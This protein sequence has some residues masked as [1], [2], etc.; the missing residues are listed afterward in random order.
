MLLSDAFSLPSLWSKSSP[1]SESLPTTANPQ[2]NDIQNIVDATADILPDIDIPDI[3]PGLIIAFSIGIIARQIKKTIWNGFPPSNNV[4]I[5]GAVLF[6]T[7][8]SIAISCRIYICLVLVNLASIYTPYLSL[9]SQQEG[10]QLPAFA[11]TRTVWVA[12]A[13]SGIKNVLF[14]QLVSGETLGRVEL[15]DRLLDFGIF[16]LASVQIVD[17]L[18][19]EQSDLG[20][21]QTSLEAGKIFTIAVSLASRALAENIVGGITL[22]AY[23]GFDEGEM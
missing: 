16:L 5:K 2:L 17:I 9:F 10:Q 20:F 21:L 19:L 11:I 23:D 15:Y 13:A 7:I 1:S 3:I 6:G 8:N 14:L 18:G 12:I 4:D 22:K